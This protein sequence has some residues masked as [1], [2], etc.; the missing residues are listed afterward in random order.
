MPEITN[1]NN[2]IKSPERN[3]LEI[4]SKYNLI[5]PQSQW[6]VVAGIV[7][8]VLK[9]EGKLS[10]IMLKNYLTEKEAME[11]LRRANA[12]HSA[13]GLDQVTFE[14][15]NTLWQ[16]FLESLIYTLKKMTARY[17]LSL[18]NLDEFLVSYP[19]VKSSLLTIT[20]FL[21]NTITKPDFTKLAAE[22]SDLLAATKL[23][24]EDMVLLMQSS[25]ISQEIETLISNEAENY[26][27]EYNLDFIFL[28]RM[29][30]AFM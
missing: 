13:R 22:R 19:D 20:D 11:M 15:I 3:V 6:A 21:I 29:L 25:K 4:W 23:D 14:Q 27:K 18:D 12:S 5:Y 28:S 16:Q 1:K 17:D 7:N 8:L 30:R 2:E 10:F 9:S 24:P 26:C